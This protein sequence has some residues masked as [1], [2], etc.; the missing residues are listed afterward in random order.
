MSEFERIDARKLAEAEKRQ[1]DV[2]ARKAPIRDRLIKQYEGIHGEVTDAARL[3]L[4]KAAYLELLADEAERELNER[5]LRESYP[6]STYRNGSR[7]N[8]S[9]GML[10]KIQTQ[11]ARLLRELRLLP[12]G[13][14]SAADEADDDEPSDDIGDY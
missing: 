9:L 2:E 5:G 1:A 11:Q 4:D 10:L 6:I 7:E 3:L 14:K 12:G 13:R 8:K